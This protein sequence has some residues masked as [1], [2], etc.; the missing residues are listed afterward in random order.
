MEAEV[1]EAM[2]A[3][4]AA[5]AA[6]AAEAVEMVEA[7]EAAEAAEVAEVA[8]AAEAAEAA[9]TAEAAEA[10]EPEAEAVVAESM[11]VMEAEA[12]EVAAVQATEVAEGVASSSEV[13][14]EEEAIR[15]LHGEIEE[16]LPPVLTCPICLEPAGSNGGTIAKLACGHCLCS[17][18]H[19]ELSS[20][21]RQ[22]ITGTVR[23]T[24]RGLTAGPQPT[25]PECRQGDLTV[26]STFPMPPAPANPPLPIEPLDDLRDLS[27]D[28]ITTNTML[29]ANCASGHSRGHP[30]YIF[31]QCSLSATRN[32]LR[33]ERLPRS[34]LVARQVHGVG[35][36]TSE[37][38]DGEIRFPDWPTMLRPLLREGEVIVQFDPT[39]I[40]ASELLHDLRLAAC[41]YAA[42]T[43]VIAIHRASARGASWWAGGVP[44]IRQRLASKT[45]RHF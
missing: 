24:R 2:E 14:E 8:E 9:E 27:G 17:S 11:E 31:A 42:T 1:A 32:L 41:S 13:Q 36:D 15:D 6:E 25:C 40:G 12:R 37:Q 34:F 18:C 22:T 44:P 43:H 33:D 7:A 28:A 10:A 4:E 45:A 35:N 21:A 23:V 5:E 29:R 3:T 19:G 26:V 39:R 20:R 30:L 38:P 16:P